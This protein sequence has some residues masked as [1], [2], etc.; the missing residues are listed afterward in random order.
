MISEKFKLRKGEHTLDRATCLLGYIGI[1]NDFG[2]LATQAV[3]EFMQSVLLHI[4]AFVACA[5]GIVRGCR[6]ECFFRA[7]ALHFVEY[8]AFSGNNELSGVTILRIFQQG[9]S[10]PYFVSHELKR[11][12]ALRMH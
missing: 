8:A 10:G 3:E 2:S 4:S 6:Y 12:L 5:Y 1:N 7:L 9:G 11:T